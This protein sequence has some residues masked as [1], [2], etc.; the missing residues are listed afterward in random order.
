MK[1]KHKNRLTESEIFQSLMG[2]FICQELP[3]NWSDLDEEEQEKFVGKNIWQPL[4]NCNPSKILELIELASFALIQL[5]E[6]KGID[7]SDS[8]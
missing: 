5:L 7:I 6:E 3:D 1:T 4:E 2:N 8:D